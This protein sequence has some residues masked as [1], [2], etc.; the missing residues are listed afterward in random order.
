MK[1]SLAIAAVSLALVSSA[2]F[3]QGDKMGKMGKP[4]TKMAGKM[5]KACPKCAKA[6]MKECNHPM[7]KADAK[8]HKAC[9]KCAKAGKKM[10]NHPMGKM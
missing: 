10:C 2:S 7:T 9:A 4:E 5:H 8:M 1:F 3:A 6:G